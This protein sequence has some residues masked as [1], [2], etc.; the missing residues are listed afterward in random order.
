V[1]DA[2]D[3]N[4]PVFPVGPSVASFVTRDFPRVP[5]E[6]DGAGIVPATSLELFQLVKEHRLY[7][8]ACCAHGAPGAQFRSGIRAYF[9]RFHKIFLDTP[10]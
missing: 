6:F 7:T 8:G 3:F 10:A 9:S 4:R 5:S 1:I 2:D